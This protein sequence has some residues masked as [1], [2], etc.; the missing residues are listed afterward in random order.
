M[1]IKIGKNKKIDKNAILGY[2][3]E[4]SI[5]NKNL[6]IG[7]NAKIRSGT[8]IYQGS[9]IGDNIETGHNVIIREENKLGHNVS[10]WSNSVIDYGCVIGD[11]VKIHTNVY[12]AQFTIIEN[13][14]FIAPGVITTN[15]LCPVCTKCMKGPTIKKG[16]KIGANVALLPHITIGEFALIGAGSV[17]TKDIPPYSL[18]YGVPARIIR[19]VTDIKCKKGIITRPYVYE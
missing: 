5:K 1:D 17:V 2:T 18:A 8:V 10:I 11:N 15:D 12:I 4:R 7:N 6:V 16:A 19:K 13:D 9:K 3:S 14:V